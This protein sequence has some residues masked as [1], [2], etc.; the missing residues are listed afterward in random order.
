MDRMIGAGCTLIVGQP[1][2]RTVPPVTTAAA[3]NGT[4]LDRSGSIAQSWAA[5]RPGA[6]RHRFT[7]VSSTAIP[8]SS[9]IAAVIAICGAEGT[10]VPVC[11]TV[12]PSSNAAPHSSS[13]ETNCEEDEASMCTVPPG[14]PPRPC[15]VNGS[16]PPS[17]S[18]PSPRRPSSSGAIGRARA[19]SSPSKTTAVLPR[20][21]R[22]GTNRSTVPASPQSIRAPGAGCRAPWTVRSAPSPVM[23]KPRVRSAPIIRSVS[24][25]RSAP[26][27]R[28]APPPWAAANAARISARLVID[29]E[30]GTVTVA[31]TGVL[32]VGADHI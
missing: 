20:A 4:A 21:A 1:L 11:T 31:C 2:M 10:E 25:L 32:T 6:T 7:S 18:T 15:T 19:C 3:A 8:A 28:E 13:P 27:I 12:S 5:T 14:A 22:G 29:F 23:S 30:P 9:S 24:R 16:P 26:S 17:M